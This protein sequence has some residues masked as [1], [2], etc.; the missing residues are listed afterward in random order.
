MAAAGFS[1]EFP[2]GSL[3]VDPRRPPS[4]R[5]GDEPY[6]FTDNG[7]EWDMTILTAID[8]S[9]NS[10]PIVEVAFDLATA[11]DEP[12]AVLHVIPEEEAT[13]HLET[14]REIP[15]FEESD[16]T[17]EADRAADFAA[18]MAE[19]AL[20]SDELDRV[21]SVGR[22]GEPAAQI[23]AVA[24]DVDARHL[25]IGG[26]KRSPV[27]KAIFGSTTQSILLNA[28]RPVTTVMHEG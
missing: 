8:E 3:G 10:T 14:L 6:V 18:T 24:R 13:E 16:V 9:Q 7:L 15:G 26:R 23:L 1:L 4:T 19:K 22:V 5:D 17:N 27:G 12:L 11:F 25:V 2:F 21:S 28:D 20:S